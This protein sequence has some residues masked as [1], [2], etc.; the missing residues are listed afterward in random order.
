LSVGGERKSKM[1]I[2]EVIDRARE[3]LER[4]GGYYNL[5]LLK[6]SFDKSTGLWELEF[7]IGIF[8]QIILKVT[9]DDNTGSITNYERRNG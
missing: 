1:Q 2:E 8:K 9:I 7:D 6:V 5:L 3:F 4:R